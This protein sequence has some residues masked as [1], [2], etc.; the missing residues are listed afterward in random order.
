MTNNEAFPRVP[1]SL[2]DGSCA[3]ALGMDPRADAA[4]PQE[5]CSKKSIE[6]AESDESAAIERET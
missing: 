5:I 3:M 4:Y 1:F 2:G 6:P